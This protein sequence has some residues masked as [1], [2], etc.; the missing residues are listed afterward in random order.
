MQNGYLERFNGKFRDECLNQ[1]WFTNLA[2]A[3]DTIAAWRDD[4]HTVRPHS[5]LGNLTPIAFAHRLR[6]PEA[7]SA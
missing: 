2:D 5:A 4:D 6:Q 1:H 3:R 7:L